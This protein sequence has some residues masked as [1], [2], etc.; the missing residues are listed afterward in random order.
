MHA[1]MNEALS[2]SLQVQSG[3]SETVLRK[4]GKKKS[5][6]SDCAGA[7]HFPTQHSRAKLKLTVSRHP[8]VLPGLSDLNLN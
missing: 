6:S 2:L 1:T 3:G 7:E 5:P 4:R 8:V